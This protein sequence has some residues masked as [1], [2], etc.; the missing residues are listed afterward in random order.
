MVNQK[1]GLFPVSHTSAGEWAQPH[2]IVGQWLTAFA[3]GDGLG[4][5][6]PRGRTVLDKALLLLLIALSFAGVF[7]HQF[8]FSM[9]PQPMSP[10]KVRNVFVGLAFRSLSVLLHEQVVVK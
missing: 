2:A 9:G 10:K 8:S 1:Q 5:V 3:Q 7:Y 6:P 4:Q